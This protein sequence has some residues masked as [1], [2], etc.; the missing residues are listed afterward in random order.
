MAAAEAGGA[1]GRPEIVNRAAEAVLA[2]DATPAQRVRVRIALI[3]LAGQA[4]ADMDEMFAAALADAGD[5]PVLLAP[6]RLRLAWQAMI[7][8]NPL[9]GEAEADKAI[10]L[11]HAAGDT[12]TEAMARRG[13]G[14]DPAG[15]RPARTTWTRSTGR[16]PCH[17][18][19]WT[20]GAP[21]ARATSPP[22]CACWT[23]GS[24]WPA[25]TC[26]GCWRWSSGAA[27]RSSVE[28]L[29]TPLRGVGP[30]RPVRRGA[31][32]RRAG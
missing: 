7:D 16:W 9:R 13:Q 19:P 29:R 10:E 18:P 27:A 5:D 1:A 17:S 2:A 32:L 14:P 21:H 20:A 22:A 30:G 4:L 11:A 26:S 31:R 25:R 15:A 23:T 3:D 28:V 12:S 8:G 24:R 6:L